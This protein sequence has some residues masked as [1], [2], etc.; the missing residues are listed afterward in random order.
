MCSQSVAVRQGTCF[1][2][3]S[4]SWI[5]TELVVFAISELGPHRLMV[6]GPRA[7]PPRIQLGS[8]GKHKHI[9]RWWA[10]IQFIHCLFRIFGIFAMNSSKFGLTSNALPKVKSWRRHCNWLTKISW[11][12]S[13][14]KLCIIFQFTYQ[15][16]SFFIWP[17]WLIYWVVLVELCS[18]AACQC[19]Y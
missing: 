8:A 15:N 1:T 18:E 19:S 4:G 13:D 7:S 17:R 6:L 2:K 16:V 11:S 10:W 12:E 9:Q 14:Q 3:W 5:L